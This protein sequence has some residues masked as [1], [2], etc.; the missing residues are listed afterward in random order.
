[1]LSQRS[2]KLCQVCRDGVILTVRFADERVNLAMPPEFEVLEMGLELHLV[3]TGP[4]RAR[5]FVRSGS[6]SA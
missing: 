6:P 2:A 1:M 3:G 4:E 5:P